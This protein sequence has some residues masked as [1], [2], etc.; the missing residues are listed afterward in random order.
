MENK[1]NL[2]NKDAYRYE[3][4][5]II[6]IEYLNELNI[7]IASHPSRFEPIYSERT[8]NNIYFDTIDFDFYNQNVDGLG[9]RDKFR[10]RWYGNMFGKIKPKI[11]IK[12]K[13]GI[14]GSK[15]TFELSNIELNSDMTG[16]QF[17]EEILKQI[18]NTNIY[19]TASILYPT[20]INQYKRKYFLSLDKKFRITL[21]T[22]MIFMKIDHN[23]RNKFFNEEYSPFNILEIKYENYNANIADE[24]SSIL[25][26]RVSKFSKYVYGMQVFY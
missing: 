9:N 2:K 10:I 18:I 1:V 24:I 19:A 4:K 22:N 3:R 11:E 15:K 20:L 6:P 14:V 25:P 7:V 12:S 8:I 26:F 16:K 21:D 5:F 23:L 13:K 17:R